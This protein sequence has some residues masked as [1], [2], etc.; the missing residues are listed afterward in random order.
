MNFYD[1]SIKNKLFIDLFLILSSVLI[2]GYLFFGFFSYFTEKEDNK[3]FAKEV[4]KVLSQ[5]FAKIILLNDLATAADINAKLKDFSNIEAVYVYNKNRKIIFSYLK[6][7]KKL[8]LKKIDEKEKFELENNLLES[9]L[10]LVYAGSKIGYVKIYLKIQTLKEIL[11]KDFL[12]IALSFFI[13]SFFAFI[14]SSVYSKKFTEPILEIVN[15]LAKLDFNNLTKKRLKTDL[16]NEFKILIDEINS[17]LDKLGYFINQ[18]KISSVAFEISEGMM[19]T[20]R[21]FKVLKVNKNYSQIT[22]Y[23]ENEVKGKLAPF[24]KYKLNDEILYEEMMK[25]LKTSYQWSGEIK[26]RKKNG[27]IY[28]LKMEI[29]AAL[30]NNDI[31][32][33][34]LSFKDISATKK[35]E[36]QVKYLQKYDPLTGVLKKD[37]FLNKVAKT[38]NY[39]AVIYLK[40]K[41]LA[42]INAVYG[43]EMGDFVIK[44]VAQI[45]KSLQTSCISRMG[46]SYFAV[47]FNDLGE[48]R[49]EK[50]KKILEII[51]IKLHSIHIKNLDIKILMGVYLF[52][53]EDAQKA[54][55][56]A[57]IA[58]ENAIKNNKKIVY[59]NEDIAKELEGSFNLYYELKNALRKK[60]F[61]LYYQ[62]QYDINGK[63]FAAESLI[64]W[65]HPK[66]G[67][68][69][70]FYFIDIIENS[71]LIYSVGD[72]VIEEAVKT[73][74]EF[75]I[76]IAVNVHPKQ[77]KEECFVENLLSKAKK[78]K[79]KP[80]LLKVELLE[81]SFVENL[82]ITKQHM[83]ELKKYGFEISIDDFGTGYSS[84]K[85][86]VN[87][88]IDQIKIDQTFVM[89]MFKEPKNI[90]VIKSIVTLADELKLNLIAEGV[91]SREHF[92]KLKEIGVK[93]FQGYHF[94]KP[95]SFEEFSLKLS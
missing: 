78:Y 5:D 41:D 28:Y 40:I 73:I 86:I 92:E 46:N 72:F 83:K 87:F 82:E 8:N 62:P 70:P 15:F 63:I 65:N 95:V 11:K 59:Y 69:T 21:D 33:F 48:N 27:E 76:K 68:L 13:I 66:R 2:V 52:K 71:D 25:S 77:F 31:K 36:N 47:C 29:K 94:S 14:I 4:V 57:Y 3:L 39:S 58:L 19:I 12:I 42:V 49:I 18:E 64:R 24:L 84:L 23:L 51:D 80:S 37:A 54:L 53:N 22:G 43:Y 79:I 56:K 1:K 67:I 10:P 16:K 60:E 89:N 34:V 7:N 30:E 26:S 50:L 81:S 93:Y 9:D 32:Y 44:K 35:L 6:N 17:M 38:K 88:P 55:K 91:E 74:K 61:L 90:S 85:Y 45:L 75:N 20:D